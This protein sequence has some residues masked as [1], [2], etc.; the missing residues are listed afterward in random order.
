MG[1][2]LVQAT[3]PGNPGETFLGL[4]GFELSVAGAILAA[5]AL[6][7]AIAQLVRTHRALTAATQAIKATQDSLAVNQLLT[8]IPEL[9]R[10]EHA[11]DEA[12]GAGD[13]AEARDRMVEWRE[14]TGEVAGVLSGRDNVDDM[15]RVLKDAMVKASLAKQR[16]LVADP[17][18]SDPAELAKATRHVRTAI[19][20]A[21]DALNVY[22]GRLKTYSVGGV[23]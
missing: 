10:A 22:F 2:L 19:G 4:D 5:I 9:Q 17:S 13:V 16:L 3:A 7:L 20:Q 12:V 6:I 23:G 8:L 15:T 14:T 18:L 21:M 1:S 11:I